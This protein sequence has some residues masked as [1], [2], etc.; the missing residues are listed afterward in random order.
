MG[1]RGRGA[2]RQRAAREQASGRTRRLPWKQKGLTRAERMIRFLQWLPIT[3]GRLRGKRMRLLPEQREFVERVFAEDARGRRPISLAVLSEPK[4]NGKSALVAGICLAALLGP[5][6]EPRGAVYSASIDRGKAGIIYE[7]MRAIILAVPEF[8]SRVNIIDFTKKFVVLE[9]DG[10]D[11]TFEALS[12]DA[13]RS[14]G[15]APTL[16]AYDELGEAPDDALLKVLME[17]EGKRNHT[18]G[19]VLSTQAD[20]DD[21][22]LSV[23]IDDALT[24]ADSSVYLQLHAAPPEAD[25]FADETIKAANPASGKFLDLDAVLKSRDR[26]RRMPSFEPAYRRLRLNQ[27][28][29]SNPE[30][31]LVQVAVWKENAAP[32]DRAKLKGRACFGGL[33]LSGKHDLTSL[34]LVFPT[35]GDD[36]DFDILPFFWTPKGQL[37]NR[38]QQEAKR[39]KQ[40]I[41]AGHLT[42]LDGATI[43]YDAV[44]AQMADLAAEFD[45]KLVGFDRYRID[46]LKPEL[47]DRNV[48]IP[49]EPFGQGFVSMGPAVER[50]AELALSGKL[51]HGAHPV[52]TA[53]V[54]NAITV[55]DPAGNL[56]IDKP[57]SNRRGPVRVDGAV[58]LVM[59]L[60]VASR[61]E[62]PAPKPS[63]DGFLKKPV[64]VI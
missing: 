35:D 13:R 48:E 29:D 61:Y 42:A 63:L 10:E 20:S 56:K 64:M 9:G 26:A 17:S 8:A 60:Q 47:E 59:A 33:D 24:G 51:R 38:T 1:L 23:L 31:R 22:P 41:D 19:I 58:A 62:P 4:G 39:F 52:L 32:V 25:P 14:Q 21:H 12:A 11:S 46:D 45:I 30:D 6:A 43:R 7:E 15:L 53:A 3:K 18:L 40:W 16:W 57:K 5:E 49:F 54:S 37:E 2:A 34:V 28:A 27:R 50:F 36:P 55:S 44:A